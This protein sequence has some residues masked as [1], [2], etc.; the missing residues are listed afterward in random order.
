MVLSKTNK[1]KLLQAINFP[2]SQFMETLMTIIHTYEDC[3]SDEDIE[4]LTDK[5]LSREK[6]KQDYPVLLR[7]DPQKRKMEQIHISG[8]YRYYANKSCAIKGI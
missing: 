8:N 3:F 6:L 7:I 2:N 5:A 4:L 1:E